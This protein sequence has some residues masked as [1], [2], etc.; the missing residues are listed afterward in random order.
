[1]KIAFFI[2]HISG[3]GAERVLT[4]LANLFSDHGHNCIMITTIKRDDEYFLNDR[5]KRYVTEPKGYN[6]NRLIG[7]FRRLYRLRKIL[8][9]ESPDYLVSF[10]NRALYHGVLT[11]RGLRT[12][13]VISVRNDPNFDYPNLWSRILAKSLL[14]LS[15]GAVFQTPDAQKWFPKKLQRKSAIIY[16]PIGTT[17]Y[18]VNY[19]PQE[20]SVVAVG[21]L[22]FQKNF[23]F[24]IN[25]FVKFQKTHKDWILH[26]YGE[27]EQM[28]TLQNLV[29]KL[30]A[31][32]TISLGGRISNVPEVI[33]KSAIYAMTS[34]FE[35]APNALMEAM[36]VGMPCISSDCPCGGPRMLITNG[37]NGFLYNVGNQEEFI[38]KLS[39]LAEN[40]SLRRDI[41]KEAK[42]KAQEFTAEK[43]YE[44]W[45]SF[46][47]TL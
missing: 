39:I 18:N 9:D 38:T 47:K 20:K 43:V 28:D 13:S 10:L 4:T 17:F 42:T 14:P 29:N 45:Y 22:N 33:S 34:D 11:T 36:A 44:A 23:K 2:E 6:G 32:D 26:I 46:I 27:G 1:M 16:N 41:G 5:I 3:G 37:E 12:K 40:E 30:N 19:F 8:K 15:E 25:S 31:K 35:G 21:R 24:L 7:P